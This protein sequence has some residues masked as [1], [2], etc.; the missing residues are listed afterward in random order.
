MRQRDGNSKVEKSSAT[1]NK[2]MAKCSSHKHKN[3]GKEL[4]TFRRP[5]VDRDLQQEI[6]SPPLP[7]L[8]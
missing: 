3:E 4:P 7:T 5:Q 6:P 1:A 2:N 8:K